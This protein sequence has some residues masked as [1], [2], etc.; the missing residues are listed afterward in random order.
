MPEF[1]I[2]NWDKKLSVISKFKDERLKYFG[3]K[4]LYME[5]PELLKKE[6]YNLIHQDI[7]KKLLSTNNEK[8]NTIPRT[9]SEIDT[10]R[11]K[12]EKENH[13]DKLV[14]LDEINAYVEELEKIYLKV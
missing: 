4:L 7:A 3:K 13:P 1:H 6:D 10:L 8:W 9:Y 5:K 12:F 2:V 14:I 11:A